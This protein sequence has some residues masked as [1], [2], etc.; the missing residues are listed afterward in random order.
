MKPP[1]YASL[2]GILGFDQVR[3]LRYYH[4]FSTEPPGWSIRDVPLSLATYWIS[5]LVS[6]IAAPVC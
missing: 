3:L 1:D 4:I 6:L 2:T 5:M